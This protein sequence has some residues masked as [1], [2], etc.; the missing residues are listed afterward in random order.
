MFLDLCFSHRNLLPRIS[1]LSL[2]KPNGFYHMTTFVCLFS[3]AW[4]EMKEAYSIY[5]QLFYLFGIFGLYQWKA[6][7]SPSLFV[8]RTD[9]LGWDY[10]K[11]TWITQRKLVWPRIAKDGVALSSYCNWGTCQTKQKVSKMYKEW[12]ASLIFYN[13]KSCKVNMHDWR[14]KSVFTISFTTSTRMHRP[15]TI[16]TF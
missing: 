14:P 3:L 16:I 11:E 10:T 4:T 2:S 12:P 15:H 9:S 8:S 6:D 5:F 7:Y 13:V 1:L